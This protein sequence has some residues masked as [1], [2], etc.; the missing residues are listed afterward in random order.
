LHLNATYVMSKLNFI[1][2]FL[3]IGNVFVSMACTPCQQ[4][5]GITQTINGTNLE[6]NFLSNAGWQCCYNVQIEIV[7]ASSNFTGTANYLSPQLC[8]NGGNAA[9]STWGPA[10]PYPPTIIDISGFCPGT[11][12]W[13]ARETQCL[14]TW[15]QEYQFTVEGASPMTLDASAADPILC[16]GESTQLTSQAANGCNGPYSYSWSP[17]AG[18]SNTTIANPIAT[19]TTTTTYTVTATEPGSCAVTQTSQVTI[20][21]NPLPTASVSDNI[22]VCLNDP[23]PTVTFTGATGT[24]PYTINYSINGVQQPTLTTTGNTVT[25]TAPTNVAGFYDYQLIDVTD[26]SPTVCSQNQNTYIT[27]TVWGLPTISAGQD[28]EICEPNP[29][30]PSDVILNGSGG[31]SYT[32]DNG[33]INNEAFIPPTGINIYTVTGTDFNGCTGTDQV[34][35]IAYPMPIANGN[36]TPLFGNVPLAVTFDNW[37]QQANNYN[38]D[39]ANGQTQATTDLSGVSTTYTTPGIYTV[40]LTASNGICFDTWTI[41]IDAYPPMIVTPPNVFTPNGD[42]SN[43]LYFVDVKWGEK[44]YGEIYNR[45]G[46]YIDFIE[47]INVGWDAT[48]EG[49]KEV[50]DGVYFIK[51]I[52]TDF[53]GNTIEGHTYFHLIR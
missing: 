6:L 38:W 5:S 2:S 14:L 52:A 27:V 45:W 28:V 44:F 13:R 10:V 47:G 49:G 40:T 43:E 25:V 39:F 36:A 21:V 23:Q 50:E 4:L 29:T 7:C 3:F 34:T 17:A 37:S 24:A 30:S 35:V 48:T 33:V 8:I 20:T 46:N 9:S 42:G 15:T 11:Y 31:V 16:V 22:A 32:W 18:L 53:K 19:P 1:F 12:K 41:D 26:S 51:Y